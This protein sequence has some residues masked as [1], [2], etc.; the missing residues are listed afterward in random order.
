MIVFESIGQIARF[1]QALL[2]IGLAKRPLILGGFRAC[3]SQQVFTEWNA[4]LA[5]HF[6]GCRGQHLRHAERL[7]VL[8]LWANCPSPATAFLLNECAECLIESRQCRS[9]HCLPLAGLGSSHHR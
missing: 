6:C 8:C 7:P 3:A 5:R 9:R 1:L 2:E 4:N